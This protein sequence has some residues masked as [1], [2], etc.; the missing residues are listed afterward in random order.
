MQLCCSTN[1]TYLTMSLIALLDARKHFSQLANGGFLSLNLNSSPMKLIWIHLIS[2]M[3]SDAELHFM[4]CSLIMEKY[5]PRLCP[6]D[7]VEMIHA[8]TI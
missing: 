6:M 5:M 1:G 2:Y 7:L 4:G 3:L 8:I